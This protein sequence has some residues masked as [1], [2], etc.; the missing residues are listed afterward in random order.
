MN[1]YHVIEAYLCIAQM[2]EDQTFEELIL[3]ISMY[4][5]PLADI[6]ARITKGI[7]DEKAFREFVKMKISTLN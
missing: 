4:D 6:L 1:D 2:P 3:K 5:P 7:E